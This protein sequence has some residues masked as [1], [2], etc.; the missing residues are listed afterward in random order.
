MSLMESLGSFFLLLF[1][2]KEWLNLFPA[3][4]ALLLK[5]TILIYALFP[6]FI[7]WT[8]PSKPAHVV[9]ISNP[10]QSKESYFQNLM[11]RVQ[12]CGYP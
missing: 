4:I 9:S 12:V 3:I 8:S 7:I 2:L 10:S 6:F 1:L 11:I 5:E